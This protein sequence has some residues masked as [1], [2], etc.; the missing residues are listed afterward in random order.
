MRP[1]QGRMGRVSGLPWATSPGVPGGLPTATV[2]QPFRLYQRASL[3]PP[4][5]SRILENPYCPV[6]R[7]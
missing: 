7:L 1:L 6:A 4:E 5:M 3:K 2:D